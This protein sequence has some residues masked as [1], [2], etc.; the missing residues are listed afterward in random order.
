MVSYPIKKGRY[1]C[2]NTAKMQKH[3]N[4]LSCFLSFSLLVSSLYLIKRHEKVIEKKHYKLCFPATINNNVLL[5]DMQY[6]PA[7]SNDVLLKDM[8]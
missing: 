7:F 3:Y 4:F 1:S 2:Q 8:H 6:S 5:K